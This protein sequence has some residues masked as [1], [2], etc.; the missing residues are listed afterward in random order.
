MAHR[1]GGPEGSIDV[2][3]MLYLRLAEIVERLDRLT[4]SGTL[5][6]EGDGTPSRPQLRVVRGTS[7]EA[8]LSEPRP[9]Y[10]QPYDSIWHLLCDDDSPDAEEGVGG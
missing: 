9:G 8:P 1:G 4:R 7:S 2:A 3:W 5:L 10:A 6:S